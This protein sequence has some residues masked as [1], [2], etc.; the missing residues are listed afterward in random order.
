MKSRILWLILVLFIVSGVSAQDSGLYID[1]TA[2]LGTISPYVY[3]ANL[4]Q[5][6][7]IPLSLMPQA[8]ALELGFARLGGGDSDRRDI[9][10]TSLDVFNY[11]AREI[12]AEPLITVRL[13]GGTPEDA[14]EAVRYVNIE[15]EYNI[16]YWSIGNE[17][18]IFLSTMDTPYTTEDLNREWRAIAE[19][20]LAVDPTILFVGPDITQ[21]V[22]LSIENDSITYI[23]G[24]GGGHPRDS[25][26]RDWLQEF[27]RA[28]GDLLSVVSLHRYP[29]PGG[30]P[31]GS[32]TVAGLQAT[33]AE[34]DASIPNLRQI[35][36]EA[37]GRDIP[38]AI[39]EINSNSNLAC[40][41]EAGVDS[42]FNALWLTDVL[43]RLIRNQVEIVTVWD[44][45][46]VGPRCYGLLTR[47]G[48]RPVYYTY[49]M[50]T[51]F[52]TE[53]LAA[54]SANPDISIYAAQ[55]EDGALTLMIVNWATE[56]QTET[57][58]IEGF[59]ASGDAEVWLFDAAPGAPHNAEQIDSETVNDGTEIMLQAQSVT[60]YVIPGTN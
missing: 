55:R 19:A 4:G 33:V 38:L 23:E 31:N 3:G 51:H 13:L 6:A 49:M 41:G 21:Y 8:Q 37:A 11:Q 56:A 58:S 25:E 48:V 53:L 35:I 30:T 9:Q 52:G 47:D 16:R 60:V 14:A 1:A 39:T 26:G 50:Y 15:K 46:G 20:M 7:I 32:A 2:S 44:I 43:G 18:N 5:N 27:L 36:R 40:G 42:F 54:E 10:L 45:Q 29:Y 28:N 17:P 12:G 57:L 22:P 34:W 59:S 24:N